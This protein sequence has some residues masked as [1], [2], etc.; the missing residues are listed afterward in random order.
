MTYNLEGN[1]PLMLSFYRE[2]VMNDAK[3]LELALAPGGPGQPKD[4]TKGN[5]A[6]NQQ[7]NT[8]TDATAGGDTREASVQALL[9]Q[10]LPSADELMS[11]A[12]Y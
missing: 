1:E 11:A 6:Q 5:A 12:I 9:Q 2:R 7:L 4:A 8:G 3:N 10:Q